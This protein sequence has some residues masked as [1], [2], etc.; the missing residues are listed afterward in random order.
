MKFG[1]RLSHEA[2][3]R[4]SSSYLDYKALKKALRDDLKTLGVHMG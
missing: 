1:K 2:S 4:W 3:R